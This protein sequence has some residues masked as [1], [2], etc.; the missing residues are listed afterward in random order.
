VA[1]QS[2]SLVAP[3]LRRRLGAVVVVAAA[4]SWQQHSGSSGSAA[5]A[6]VAAARQRDCGSLVVELAWLGAVMAA[7]A[8]A[9]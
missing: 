9:W 6:A 8:A 7:A 1:S 5:V 4:A 3:V 2:G